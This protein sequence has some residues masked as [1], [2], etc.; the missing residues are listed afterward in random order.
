MSTDT[1]TTRPATRADILA[2]YGRLPEG[3]AR[4]W[5]LDIG[6]KVAGVAGYRVVGGCLLA[7]SDVAEGVPKMTVWRKAHEF[8]AMLKRTTYCEGSEKS[9]PFLERLGWQHLGD[10]VY[11]YEPR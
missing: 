2:F 4:V 6:G 7:F 3:S 8:M 11:R 9:G 5:V 1:I 10:H